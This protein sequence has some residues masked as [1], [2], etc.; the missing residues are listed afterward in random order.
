MTRKSILALLL[1]VLGSFVSAQASTEVQMTGDMRMYGVWHT[2]RNYTGWNNGTWTGNSPTSFI[3]AGTKTEDSFIV[4]ERFRI[5]AD[6]VANEALKFRLGLRVENTWG[7]G[8]YT[9]ANPAAA[10]DVYLAYLQFKWPNT[11]ME[12]TAGLQQIDLPQS[13]MFFASPVWGGER[14]AGLT[15]DIPVLPDQFKVLVNYLRLLDT[16]RTYDDTTTQVGDELDAFVLSLPIT[17]DGFKVNPWAM[18]AVAGK[19]AAYWNTYMGPGQLGTYMAAPGALVSP[20]GFKAN[21]N[22]FYW[23][24]SSLEIKA[25]SPVNFYA[26][27][28]YGTG[29]LNDSKKNHRE[30]WLVD[31]GAEYTGWD[32]LTPE[33]F[34]WYG[35]GE[36]GS[37]RNGSERLALIKPNWGPGN[38]WLFDTDLSFPKDGNQGAS[39][40][41]CTG[42]WA[43]G[44][45]LQKIS[46]IEKLTHRLTAVYIQ[47]TNSA[48]AIRTLNTLVGSNPYFTMGRDLT[49]NEHVIGVNLDHK[50]QLYEN[51]SFEVEAGWSH[52][53]FQQSVW[54]HRLSAQARSNDNNEWKVAFGFMYRY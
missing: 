54:G 30:G 25:L 14:I 10:V 16:N 2:N 29:G 43:V 13:T 41:N 9:A 26:D 27:F 12:V 47:G 45:S 51:L 3:G 15:L 18:A 22:A 37:I 35:S 46:F 44:A 40:M 5:R 7:M 6:F 4:W 39:G 19:S 11:D 42:N 34:A 53:Q 20:T 38:S 50:Y 33:V 1:L 24:G 52:G 23:F 8:T 21:Q 48:K 28:I 32:L 31:F 17:V 49:T 36:D